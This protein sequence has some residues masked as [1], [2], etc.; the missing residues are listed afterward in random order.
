MTVRCQS[1]ADHEI[2][3]RFNAHAGRVY[4]AH[5][6]GGADE[7]L[8][9]PARPGAPALIHYRQDFAQ[10]ALHELAHWCIAGAAR[11]ALP[12]Y[13]YWYQPPPRNP[14]MRARFFAVESRV[15]GLERLLAHVCGVRFHV[16]LDD[17]GSDPQD[18]EARVAA[19]TRAWLMRELPARTQAVLQALEPDWRQRLDGLEDGLEDELEDELVYDLVDEQG[20]AG[21]NA[22]PPR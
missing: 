19:S 9:E 10:S 2:A 21:P 3:A 4:H 20:D 16:S 14:A 1:L 7:P 18:F 13:G 22:G 5:L 8:Y 17:P 6:Q 11:R 12:D 15:Q